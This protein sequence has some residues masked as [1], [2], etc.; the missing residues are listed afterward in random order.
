[1]SAV[2]LQRNDEGEEDPIY[3]MSIPLKNREL[4]YFLIEKHTFSV[5]KVVKQFFYYILHSHCTVFVPNSAVKS[6][7]TQ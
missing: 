3:L 5:V 2:L 4:Q 1:M 6:L 7:L